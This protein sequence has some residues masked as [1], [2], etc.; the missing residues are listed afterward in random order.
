M[1][2]ELKSNAMEGNPAE[3]GRIYLLPRTP[4]GTSPL[5]LANLK[6]DPFA[7]ICFWLRK[8]DDNCPR[9]SGHLLTACVAQPPCSRL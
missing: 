2:C 8:K 4:T 3:A 9:Q 7:R 6:W 1:A 5:C